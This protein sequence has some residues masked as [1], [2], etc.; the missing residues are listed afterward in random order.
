[1]ELMVSCLGMTIHE[2]LRGDLKEAMKARDA[3][4]LRTIRGLITMATNE[5]VARKEKPDGILD[6]E[7]MQVVLKRA[8]KQRKES[9]EQFETGGRPDLASY[10]REELSV[11]ETYLPEQMSAEE[12]ERIARAKK[13]E[14][15]VSDASKA[16]ILV[17]AVMKEL[18]GQAD[19][20]V[21]KSVVDSLFAE[22]PRAE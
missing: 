12:V 20:A 22:P 6:D 15:G 16:G 8:A 21:V 18:K 3:A 14:L 1:M 4:R 10:E 2:S 19:G 5:L 13:E 11:I 17:G 9:I 7:A